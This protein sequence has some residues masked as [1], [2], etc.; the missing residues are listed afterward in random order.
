M[1]SIDTL[2][3]AYCLLRSRRKWFTGERDTRGACAEGG[4]MLPVMEPVES[5]VKCPRSDGLLREGKKQSLGRRK[6]HP[7]RDSCLTTTTT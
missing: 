3:P 7:G 4:G 2:S 5:P 1:D 6:Y